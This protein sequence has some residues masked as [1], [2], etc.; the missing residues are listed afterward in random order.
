[1]LV[2][3]VVLQDFQSVSCEVAE[4]ASELRVVVVSDVMTT[5]LAVAVDPL[6][7]LPVADAALV[8]HHVTLHA[9]WS[10]HL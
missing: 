9:T 8:K 3:I 4:E 10:A 2:L 5:K 7:E 6:L 1:M